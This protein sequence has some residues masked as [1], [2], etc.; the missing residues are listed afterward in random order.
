MRDVGVW[1]V[2]VKRSVRAD[3][4]RH[5]RGVAEAEPVVFLDGRAGGAGGAALLRNSTLADTVSSMPP[6]P[7]MAAAWIAAAS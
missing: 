2:A 7:L 1:F 3:E 5:L 6:K 4:A